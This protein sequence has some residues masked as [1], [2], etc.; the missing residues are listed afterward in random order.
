MLQPGKV[1]RDRVFLCRWMRLKL[2]D[3][4]ADGARHGNRG[5]VD[6]AM[7]RGSGRLGTVAL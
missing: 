4:D 6:G 7:K 1:L 2:A 5:L 3:C